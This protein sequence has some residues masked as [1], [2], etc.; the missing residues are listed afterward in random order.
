MDDILRIR[1]G[2]VK[3]SEKNL[4]VRNRIENRRQGNKNNKE[5]K[6]SETEEK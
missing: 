2:I 4:E 6:R 1:E 3:L 5:K